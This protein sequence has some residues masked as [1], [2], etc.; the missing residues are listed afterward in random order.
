[1]RSLLSSN[2]PL[3]N[4]ELRKSRG[5]SSPQCRPTRRSARLALRSHRRPRGR[6]ISPRKP[7]WPSVLPLP[8]RLTAAAMLTTPD[9][10]DEIGPT[11]QRGRNLQRV[12]IRKW[13]GV[14]GRDS[15]AQEERGGNQSRLWSPQRPGGGGRTAGCPV[16]VFPSVSPSCC[17]GA[18]ASWFRFDSSASFREKLPFLENAVLLAM[19]QLFYSFLFNLFDSASVLRTVILI[20]CEY[21]GE[22]EKQKIWRIS[23]AVTTTFP[24]L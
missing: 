24:A 23:P 4:L 8:R 11:R 5:L 20:N 16:A 12:P 19:L 9:C 22:Y 3:V 15:K 10:V 6:T 17:V 2:D 1:M 7:S 14:G 13:R 21:P 18:C